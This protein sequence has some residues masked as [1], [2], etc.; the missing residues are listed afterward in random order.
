MEIL[1]VSYLLTG[2][3][4]LVSCRIK[5]LHLV[6]EVP[7]G[8]LGFESFTLPKL[9]DLG[10]WWFVLLLVFLLMCLQVVSLRGHGGWS[11]GFQSHERAFSCTSIGKEDLEDCGSRAAV[12]KVNSCLRILS[13]ECLSEVLPEVAY[14]FISF[15]L[16]STTQ[17]Q[18]EVFPGVA[19][20]FLSV[21]LYL[22]SSFT[23]NP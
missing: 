7:G 8:H 2:P 1:G 20:H 9:R 10:R 4:E 5:G 18:H 17:R 11:A 3:T 6:A 19:Y 21:S 15:S 12:A 14:H 22:T 16:F 13:Q 23:R